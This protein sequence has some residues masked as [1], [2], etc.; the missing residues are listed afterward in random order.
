[1][2]SVTLINPRGTTQDVTELGALEHYLRR[3]YQPQTG[4]VA[5]ARQTFTGQPDTPVTLGSTGVA[6]NAKT[7]GATGDGTADDTA[8]INAALAACPEGAEVYLPAGVYL[9]TSPITL[10]R[11]RT[12]RGAH[13]G[14][15]PYD[16]GGPCSIRAAAGFT[17][18]AIIR[19]R[20][21][22][23]LFGAVGAPA[24]GLSVGPNDQSGMAITRLAID[25]ANV[26]GPIDG[27]KATG[28]ARSV[29]ITD[30]TVRRCTGY[31]IRTAVYVRAD[32][33]NNYPRGWALQQVVADHCTLDG[34]RFDLLND[35][36]LVDCVAGGNG[37]AG[38]RITGA[39]ELLIVGCRAAWNFGGPGFY[40]TGTTYGNVVLSACSTDRNDQHG[41]FIDAQGRTPI[42]LSG[43]TLR[44]DGRNGGAGGANR[45]GVLVAGATTPV[46][47]SG[48]TT[49]TGI[50]DDN[51]SGAS[52][53]Q[54]GLRVA[55]STSVTVDSGMLWGQTAAYLDGGGNTNL[56]LGA[57]VVLAAGS[58]TAP[59]FSY[60]PDTAAFPQ[61]AEHGMHAWS[62]DPAVTNTASALTSGVMTLVKLRTT[63][64]ATVASLIGHITTPGSGLTAGQCFAG[65]YNATGTLIGSTADQAAAWAV[66]GQKV[67]T[68]TATATGSL[69]SLPPGV[70]YAAL[71]AVGTTMP[72]FARASG[73][74]PANANLGISG[75]RFATYGTGQ[76]ALPATFTLGSMGAATTAWWIGLA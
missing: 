71:L 27:I 48:I 75:T 52:S 19:L 44:R 70:Y 6:I 74:G 64:P 31:G 59:T 16:T 69:T 54:Y 43:V 47:I 67:M 13:S 55:S 56:R 33:S 25:G 8:A 37:V 65:L 45:S 32:A 22:E 5:A 63:A 73:V 30:V 11:N 18:D 61:P 12:L 62:F 46:V 72:Q 28:L 14:R 20:D 51:V 21:E 29:R 35:S 3:G 34:F 9:T 36:T 24:A 53:P 57:R 50:D 26:A 1:M 17:G 4:T 15:W 38:Y 41:I 66:A 39:G 23:E 58:S 60:L 10:R 7:Y 49:Q 42:L 68:L 76:T 40:L 2:P